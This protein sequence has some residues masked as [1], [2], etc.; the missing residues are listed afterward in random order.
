[1]F[2]WF[3]NKK[4]QDSLLLHCTF[5]L[6]LHLYIIDM[7]T[8]SCWYYFT[9]QPYA[10]FSLCVSHKQQL[11]IIYYDDDDK[12]LWTPYQY[13]IFPFIN[14]CKHT[15]MFKMGYVLFMVNTRLDTKNLGNSILWS[16]FRWLITWHLLNIFF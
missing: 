10:T 8:C 5:H 11:Y 15:Y 12:V 1:M 6:T 13:T 4:Q 16:F 14:F 9:V 2:Y 7:Q 3:S